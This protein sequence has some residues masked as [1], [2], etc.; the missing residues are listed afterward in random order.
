M[1]TGV[2]RLASHNMSKH[3]APPCIA[4]RCGGSLNC[5]PPLMTAE[6]LTLCSLRPSF[7]YHQR[8][9]PHRPRATRRP[10]NTAGSNR[11][12]S[13]TTENDTG[14]ITSA[15]RALSDLDSCDAFALL[16]RLV[17]VTSVLP[18][19]TRVS[20]FLHWKRGSRNLGIS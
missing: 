3:P 2:S 19:C 4:R 9:G 12:L 1:G 14:Q 6:C 10:T 17:K 20:C 18:K 11:S 15:Q 13:K 7:P 8:Y 16:A 5:A